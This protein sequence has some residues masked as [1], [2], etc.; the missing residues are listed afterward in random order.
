MSDA[1]SAFLK[2]DDDDICDNENRPTQTTGGSRYKL[3]LFPLGRN[4]FEAR[5]DWMGKQPGTNLPDDMCKAITERLFFHLGVGGCLKRTSIVKGFTEYKPEKGI[6]F[7]AHPDYVIGEPW[8]DWAMIKWS[9]SSDLVP[10]RL[11]LFL[12]LSDAVIM[13]QDEHNVFCQSTRRQGPVINDGQPYPYLDNG[14]WV[15]IQSAI[16]AVDTN[17]QCL[18]KPSMKMCTRFRLEPNYRLVPVEAITDT[19][20]CVLHDPSNSS[21]SNLTGYMLKKREIWFN[22]FSTYFND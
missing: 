3:L 17:Q 5:L 10:A 2:P 12:D 16:D 22:A 14:Q 8:Y 13:S 1:K 18:N 4:S 7:R 6:I 21:D 20:F 19:A 9:G 15:L 11:K